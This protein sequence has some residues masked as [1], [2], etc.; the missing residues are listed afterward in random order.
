M[1]LS[2]SEKENKYLARNPVCFLSLYQEQWY[3]Q[4]SGTCLSREFLFSCF[5]SPL[6]LGANVCDITG[7]LWKCLFHRGFRPQV[8]NLKEEV[9]SLGK[10]QLVCIKMGSIFGRKTGKENSIN[11]RLFQVF[12]RGFKHL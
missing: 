10:T 5:I 7:L 4:G 9:W 6:K 2:V 11:N 12:L 8:G 3:L 1:F